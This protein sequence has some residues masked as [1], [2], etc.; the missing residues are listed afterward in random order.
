MA[1]AVPAS[2]Q[3]DEPVGVLAA[4]GRP[5]GN[6]GGRTPRRASELAAPLESPPVSTRRRKP[7]QTLAPAA[8]EAPG[9]KPRKA[10]PTKRGDTAPRRSDSK[11][12]GARATAN[13]PQR[14]GRGAKVSRPKPERAA[15]PEPLTQPGPALVGG[16]PLRP[17]RGWARSLSAPVGRPPATPVDAAQ[18]AANR[19]IGVTIT[20]AESKLGPEPATKSQ[21][22][23]IPRS[24]PVPAGNHPRRFPPTR[25]DPGPAAM[26]APDGREIRKGGGGGKSLASKRP[27]PRTVASQ[28]RAAASQ[29][30]PVS[31]WIAL[32]VTAGLAIA[33]LLVA[34]TVLTT[35]RD[36]PAV[37]STSGPTSVA[38]ARWRSV[39]ETFD[40]LPMDSKLAKPW[41][42]SGGGTAQIVALPTSVDRSVRISSTATGEATSACRT[43]AVVLGGS[44][45]IAV[46]FLV[47]R[48]PS[49]PIPLMSIGSGDTP[50]LNLG[51]DASGAPVEIAA[52][53]TVH[54]GEARPT[55]SNRSGLPT[56]QRL[57]LAINTATGGVRWQVH[58]TSGAQTGAGQAQVANLVTGAFDTICFLSP[59]GSPSGW[60]AID[61]LV[62]EG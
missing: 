48:A 11:A 62:V 42:V 2:E 21:P 40:G 3:S 51:L 34:A 9:V 30:R 16:L 4:A 45:R 5:K 6:G 57:E 27:V 37:A 52:D 20:E 55:A 41:R 14:P 58:D 12:S 44:I 39:E 8:E 56:W 25:L 24:G 32:L 15:K 19:G 43:A 60:T 31:S 13:S 18:V 23:V 47:S 54:Q 33:A 36:R 50:Q 49:S 17:E 28:P 35:P 22:G 38:A 53:G 46:D 26:P 1:T 61:D 7:H 10:T 29:T 59:Q